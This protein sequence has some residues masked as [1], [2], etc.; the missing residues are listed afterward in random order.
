VTD[1]ICL[2]SV[3]GMTVMAFS[4]L[5]K[6]KQFWS[7]SILVFGLG[8]VSHNDRTTS[9]MTHM[10]TIVFQK[11]FSGHYCYSFTSNMELAKLCFYKVVIVLVW[12]SLMGLAL[13]IEENP[14]TLGITIT[15]IILSVMMC[16]LCT[17]N[18]GL[19]IIYLGKQNFAKLS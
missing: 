16:F 11:L 9:S 14:N 18:R 8:L 17:V 4:F 5:P 15:P 10:L 19:L 3:T 6:D 1:S 12:A 2:L 13:W 7:I